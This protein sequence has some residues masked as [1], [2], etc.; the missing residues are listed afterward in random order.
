VDQWSSYLVPS[1]L[2]D[3]SDDTVSV[4]GTLTNSDLTKQPNGGFYYDID[5]LFDYLTVTLPNQKIKGTNLNGRIKLMNI[6]RPELKIDSVVGD[7]RDLP[8]QANGSIYFDTKTYDLQYRSLSTVNHNDLVN[9][10]SI[11]TIPGVGYDA[12]LTARL[13]GSFRQPK[14]NVYIGSD[15]VRV[16]EYAVGPV[17]LDIAKIRDGFEFHSLGASNVSVSGKIIQHLMDLKVDFKQIDAPIFDH[18]VEIILE[19]YGPM[20]ALKTSITL[21]KLDQ[22]VFGYTINK[23]QS[24]VVLG[25][26]HLDIADMSIQLDNTQ[27]IFFEGRYEFQNRIFYLEQTGLQKLSKLMNSQRIDSMDAQIN[28]SYLNGDWNVQVTSNITG[29]GAQ[30]LGIPI[31]EYGFNVIRN[32]D[33]YLL[34]VDY[35]YSE[36]QRFNGQIIFDRDKLKVINAKF[37]QLQLRHI[38]PFIPSLRGMGL[39]GTLTGRVSYKQDPR[40]PN[41]DMA[42][43]IENLSFMQGQLGNIFIEMVNHGDGYDILNFRSRGVHHLNLTGHLDSMSAFEL[44]PMPGSM[45]RLDAFDYFSK[46][47]LVGHV[48]LAGTLKGPLSDLEYDGVIES[49]DFEFDG[50]RFDYVFS[51]LK[52]SSSSV[53]FRRL[54][55]EHNGGKIDIN[56][57]IQRLST[58]W[59]DV[60]YSLNLGLNFSNF[61]M[62]LFSNM[63]QSYHHLEELRLDSLVDF[64]LNNRFAYHKYQLDNLSF[65][66]EYN[67]PASTQKNPWNFEGKMN[68]NI[69]VNTN[70]I[71]D[72]AIDLTVDQFHWFE[73]FSAKHLRIASNKVVNQRQDYRLSMDGVVYNDAQIDYF[74]TLI[75]FFPKQGVIKSS[76]QNIRFD[77]LQ[78]RNIMAWSYRLDDRFFELNMDLKNNDLAILSVVFMPIKTIRNNGRVRFSLSGPLDQMSLAYS[79]LNLNKF[80]LSFDS[81]RS[82][83]N[84]SIMVD[85]ANLGVSNNVIYFDSLNVDWKGVDTYRRVTRREKKNNFVLNGSFAIHNI[86]FTDRKELMAQ[87]DLN[88]L[89]SFFSVNFPLFYS[90]DILS[91]RL[92]FSGKQTYPLDSVGKQRVLNTLGTTNESGPTLNGELTFRDGVFNVPKL[93]A[94]KPKMRMGLDL[95]MTIDPGNY[96]QGSIIGDGVYNLAN[97]VS[98]EIHEKMQHSPF[99]VSGMLNSPNMSTAIQFY[100]GSVTILDGVYELIRL[101]QQSHYFKEMPELISDQFVFIRPSQVDGKPGLGFDIHL[102]GLRKKDSLGVTENI[103]QFNLPFSAIGLVIDGDLRKISQGFTVLDFGLDSYQSTYPNYEFYGA[104]QVNLMDQQSLSQQ[105]QYG[106]TLIMPEV[107]TNSEVSNFNQYG[108]QQVNSFVKSSIRPYE[109]RLARRF[110]LYD[111]RLDYDFGR[112]FFY[113]DSDVFQNQDL[114]GISVVSNLYKE[115]MF[116]TVRSDVDLSSDESVSYERGIKI[117]QLELKYFFEPNFSVGMK[118]INEYA[119]ITSF[120]PR[121]SINYGYAF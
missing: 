33:E 35:F 39:S 95:N 16:G 12:S 119:D 21:P 1:A 43:D 48:K 18:P 110:G 99:K 100:E 17:Y 47:K 56:G 105:S 84:A 86:D 120:D 10:L 59:D 9:F 83:F 113:S 98:L 117:T 11:Q 96:V 3:V 108:R 73:K 109:R 53:N 90:G 28:M 31:D 75:H 14:F 88:V 42:I 40:A 30:F 55:V 111:F 89:P 7:Y 65:F 22:N 64:N 38:S 112:S 69:R 46:Q 107:I 57:N 102:R 58:P 27:K 80:K 45:I 82:N 70:Q 76:E 78:F 94:K 6:D 93:G 36:G 61:D 114:L 118:N 34:D 87:Y 104:Y 25:R 68:G 97:N 116:L 91:S 62:K 20:D 66:N 5:V 37:S 41:L 32:A 74:D 106:L 79:E 67:G 81:D 2:V 101:D 50:H 8:I 54:L 13:T 4:R 44:S 29:A 115:K 26:D 72:N 24:N 121:L 103:R 63:F 51:D 49:D 60:D 15:S 77:G 52:A 85:H 19:A 92:H 23:I 71:D